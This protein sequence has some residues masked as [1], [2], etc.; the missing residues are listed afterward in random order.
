MALY[1]TI[2]EPIFKERVWGGRSLEQLYRKR[3]PPAVNIGESWEISDR[4]GDQS[5]IAN[6]AF[7]GRTLGWLM[8]EHGAEVLG[9]S[10]S[11]PGNRFPLLCKI[12]DA[13]ERLSLQVHPRPGFDPLA[14]PKTEMWYI[15]GAEA[16]AE[17]FVGLRQG[18]TRERFE[19]A[20]REGRVASCFHRIA[21]HTDDVMFLPSGRVHAI[22]AGLV[23]FEIQQNS[24]TTYRVYDWDR[25]GADGRPRELHIPQSLANI[26][27]DDVE[28]SLVPRETRDREV[29]SI[30]P[31]VR[32]P[33]F[34]ADLIESKQH[35]DAH[36]EPGP[37]RVIAV[38]R[39]RIL[40]QGGGVDAALEP[41]GFCLLPGSTPGA[42]VVAEPG[43][44]YLQVEAGSTGRA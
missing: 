41:G 22:G 12:L 16:G 25:V 15:A 23:I 8:R 31:L 37:A 33:L 17:L 7:A 9:S 34:S 2:F 32:D 28:P 6:G 24:D 19:E 27:F 1:P 38:V 21:V 35:N 14:E 26:D 30:R 5:M 43:S 40:V 3:L 11:A 10:T 20:I 18:A 42:R 39:G 44:T 4:D 29:G 13:R 36:V